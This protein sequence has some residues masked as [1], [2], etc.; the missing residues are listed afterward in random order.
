MKGGGHVTRHIAPLGW[1]HIALTGDYSWERGDRPGLG[2]LRPLRT[3]PSL[4]AA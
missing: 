4:L 3:S 2:Q 1:E